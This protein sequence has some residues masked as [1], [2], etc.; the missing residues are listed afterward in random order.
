MICGRK[1]HLGHAKLLDTTE[2][3]KLARV[4]QAQQKG[5]SLPIL[6]LDDV[7][8]WVTNDRGQ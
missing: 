7:M 5:I 3:L 1:H 4:Y 6:K 8:H 2:A